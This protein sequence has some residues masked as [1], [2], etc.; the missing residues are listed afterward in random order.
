MSGCGN[1]LVWPG[2]QMLSCLSSHAL[3]LHTCNVGSGAMSCLGSGMP[4]FAS[5]HSVS[6]GVDLSSVRIGK[7]VS[8]LEAEG[9]GEDVD[10][11]GGVS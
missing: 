9:G 10:R 7:V 1:A 8:V 4:Y 11:L 6:A 3:A 5:G 2:R